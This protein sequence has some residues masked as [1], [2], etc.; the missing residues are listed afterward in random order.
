M[1]RTKEPYF[2]DRARLDQASALAPKN[3]ALRGCSVGSYRRDQPLLGETLPNPISDTFMIVVNLRRLDEHHGWLNGSRVGVPRLRTGAIAALD[4]RDAWISEQPHPFHTFHAFI[5]QS[6]FDALTDEF[7]SPPVRVLSCR[8][9]QETLD[10][11]ML[12]LAQALLPIIE[13]S[14]M[15]SGLFVD[16][17]LH[18]MVSHLALR[19]GGMTMATPQSG[20]LASWQMRRVE[21]LML[22]DLSSN[23]SI[24][25]LARECGL[26]P[27]QFGRAFV[28]SNGLPAHRWRNER[29]I[30]R[31][32]E[33]LSETSIPLSVV[34]ITCGFFDQSHF[35]KVFEQCVGSSPGAYR[36]VRRS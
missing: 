28:K 35:S 9:S 17:V 29:R 26:S 19:Y 31:A 36:R 23:L 8:T 4:F 15:N 34:A 6:T 1:D 2:A 22:A 14:Q 27:R 25:Q 5:P 20:G 7:K 32:K 24:D 18:A 30:Q 11:A 10:P 13:T 3:L 21:D 16:H 12:G 33:M